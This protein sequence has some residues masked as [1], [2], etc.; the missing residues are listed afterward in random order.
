MN[1][2]QIINKAM[3]DGWMPCGSCFNEIEGQ[4]INTNWTNGNGYKSWDEL[5]KIYNKGDL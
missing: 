3:S 5:K 1:N 4:Y 2:S